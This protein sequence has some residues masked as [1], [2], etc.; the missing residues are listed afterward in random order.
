MERM[1]H[2]AWL[3]GLLLLLGFPL[4]QAAGAAEV[5]IL[6]RDVPI[7]QAP[8]VTAPLIK[9]AR[10]GETYE[11][12]GRKTGKGQPL[13]NLDERG[14]LWVKVRLGD[15]ALGYLRTDGVSVAHEDFRS[16]KGNTTLLVNLR[17][18]AD[19]AIVQE[20]WLV[21]EGWHRIRRLAIIE[22]RPVWASNGE[23]FLCQV[24]SERPIK[25]QTMDRNLER[26]ERFSADGRSRNTLAAG[27]YPLLNETRGEVYFYRDLDEQGELVPPGLFAVNVDGSNLHP[28]FLLPEGYRFWREEGDFYVQAPSPILEASANR[29]VLYGYDRKGVKSRFTITPEGHLFELRID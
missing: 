20:L 21:P 15:E 3:L 18:T 27:T 17:P 12:V 8:Q 7:L 24:D 9:T 16:P 5:L 25:D 19:G 2:G 1:R 13:Y 10:P 6:G 29:I 4:A 23:W 26:I 22:G 28:L 11:V 14:N